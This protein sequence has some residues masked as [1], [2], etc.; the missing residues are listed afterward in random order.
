[1]QAGVLIMDEKKTHICVTHNEEK[2]V[3]KISGE[4][5]LL[6]FFPEDATTNMVIILGRKGNEYGN[7]SI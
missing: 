3:I 2:T 1:M 7:K 4:Y 6:G 5:E